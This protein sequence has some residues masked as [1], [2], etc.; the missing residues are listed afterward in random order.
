MKTKNIFVASLMAVVMLPIGANAKNPVPDLFDDVGIQQI[1]K[2]LPK[3]AIRNR[4]VNIHS[5]LLT[6]DT[7]TLNL[8][9]DVIVTAVRD[10]LI[11]NVKGSTTWIGHV[12]GE[13]ES[14]VFLTQRGNAISGTVQIG[15]KTYDIEPKGNNKHD[16]TQVD[17]D[18]NPKNDNDTVTAEDFL[19]TGGE[20]DTTG[21][22]TIAAP[23][24]SAATVGTVIDLMVAYTSKAKNNASGQA[25]IEAKITNAVAM[26][27]QAYINSK[28]D[29]QL[30]L[31]KMVETSYAETGNMSTSLTD[32]TGTGDGKMDELHTLRN[33]V[34]ADQV[35]LITA[36]SNY[37]G[38]GYK[39][40]SSWIN[41]GFSA[42]AFSV[43]HDDSVYACL[44]NQSMAHEL[45]HNQGN[46]HDR[47]NS[48]SAAAYDY[49]YGYKLCQTGGFRT[50]MSY[51]CTGANRISYFSNPN[52]SLSTGEVTGTATENNA[53]SMNNNKDIV[54]AFR[55]TVSTAVP[56]APSNLAASV[57][58]ASQIN[59]AWT[60]NA[61]D[62]TGFR[63]ERSADGINW[64]EIAVT[65]S[66]IT[67]FSDTGLV[68]STTYQ[69][70][71]RTYNSNGNSVYSNIGSATT[72]AQAVCSSTAP[73]V[74]LTPS[75]IYSKTGATIS[76][77]VSL[78][79]KDSSVCS[80]TTF[81]LT[82]SDGGI[83]GSYAL[84]PASSTTAIWTLTA[85]TTDGTYSAAVTATA[86]G[87]NN[88]GASASV[89]VDGTVPT[90]PGNLSASVVKRTQIALSW[91]ASTDSGSGFDHYDI[92]R[93]GTKISTTTSL[94]YTDKPG[95]KGT[96]TY[97]V[98]AF[99]KAGN[100]LGASKSINF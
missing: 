9:D 11:D 15:T 73:T 54:A 22:L 82:N 19:A 4:S 83:I 78:T 45:G 3:K 24:A 84:S 49:S 38:I 35:S 23:T 76:F 66:N 18:R 43:V 89:I 74:V 68:A 64:S 5:E 36:E 25:G 12:E 16:I 37:C 52:V 72:A 86:A 71:V 58:S 95:S 32:L 61:N 60:D 29:I 59:I 14:E 42:Y 27:N 33:Q 90:A 34:G 1:K 50:V 81:T 44:S 48:T 99:D 70:R 41:T 7:I 100:S 87:H 28:V 98:Q 93:N 97:T 80:A 10:R 47:D 56:N 63:L 79:N 21:N 13:Q 20:P 69:Y 67:S 96:Y 77:N 88:A 94:K 62:E 2:A 75:S 53:L 51:A 39:M 8:F 91:T 31:V 46:N 17:P 26:A 92:S 85:P 30:N 40:T 65:N 6:G 55:S 57:Q